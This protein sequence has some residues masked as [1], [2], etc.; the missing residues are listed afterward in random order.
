MTL[1][2]F[3]K[4]ATRCNTLQH[5]ATRCNTLQHAAIHC[6]THNLRKLPNYEE[7]ISV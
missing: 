3:A 5:A 2:A 6:N 7:V 1:R 4:I